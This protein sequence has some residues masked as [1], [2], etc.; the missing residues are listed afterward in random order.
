MGADVISRIQY[1]MENPGGLEQ[2]RDAVLSSIND[3]LGKALGQ[4]QLH[5]D[6]VYEICVCGNPVMTQ[7]FLGVDPRPI[8]ATPF[9]PGVTRE[10]R[11][12][13]RDARVR[14]HACARLFTLPGVAGYVGADAIGALLAANP[15]QG[16]LP[17]LILD[18]G[19]NAEIMLVCDNANYACAAAAGPALEGAHLS[20]GMGAWPGALDRVDISA[21][22]VEFTTI[23]IANACGLCGT[24]ALDTLAG[25]LAAGVVDATG[26]FT[27][28]ETWPNA[29]RPHA[30]TDHL[31]RPAFAVAQSETDS[32]IL[33]TQ[34]DVRQ[35]QLARG[36][37]A[38]G[39]KVLLQTAGV[40]ARDLKAVLC[41][42]ALGSFLRPCTALAAG[43]VP[44]VPEERIRF[45]GNA[46]LAGA[47]RALLNRAERARARELA[48]AVTYIELSGRSDF[49]A[50]FESCLRFG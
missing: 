34:A 3:M 35:L 10:I 20:H 5:E 50:A 47:A 49:N 12:S 17:A 48:H 43:L 30:A 6:C 2:L 24:G 28:A 18:F 4:A 13:A 31:G 19:T 45:L 27:A 25:L 38:A 21:H 11:V 16:D 46:A 40:N 33:F 8:A 15:G 14:G 23:D 7:I 26:R 44:D 36:A 29:L 22:K 1:S 9:T 37:I 41:A 42:G 39:T 32:K